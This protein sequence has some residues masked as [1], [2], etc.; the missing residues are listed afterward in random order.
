[1][2]RLRVLKQRA[3]RGNACVERFNKNWYAFWGTSFFDADYAGPMSKREAIQLAAR[4]AMP[5]PEIRVRF[6]TD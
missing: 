4:A 5:R 6:T 3:R 1:M 2:N